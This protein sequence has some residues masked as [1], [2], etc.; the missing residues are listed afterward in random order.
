MIP[1]T[2]KTQPQEIAE[3]MSC[4]TATIK[5]AK[6]YIVARGSSVPEAPTYVWSFRRNW[7]TNDIKSWQLPVWTPSVRAVRKLLADRRNEELKV[8]I[9]DF[10]AKRL[11]RIPRVD[12]SHNTIVY[13]AKNAADHEDFEARCEAAGC[14]WV[15][16][17]RDLTPLIKGV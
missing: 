2:G 12:L 9:W 16:G 15:D 11:Y 3:M 7:W 6:V 10:S 14:K 4:F 1:F 8:Y 17:Y 13:W 5:N